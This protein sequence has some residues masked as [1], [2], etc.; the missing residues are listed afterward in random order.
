MAR[1]KTEK[2]KSVM[3]RVDKRLLAGFDAKCRKANI[4][5]EGAIRR[6]MEKATGLKS[7][8]R[9]AESLSHAPSSKPQRRQKGPSKPKPNGGKPVPRVDTTPKN[10]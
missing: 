8:R 10:D 1:K 5:R 9:P 3:F 4:T 6:A 2:L 7:K